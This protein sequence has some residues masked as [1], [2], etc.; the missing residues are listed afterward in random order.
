MEQESVIAYELFG[1]VSSTWRC[2]SSV[3]H[4]GEA[5]QREK[6]FLQLHNILVSVAT[7]YRLYTCKYEK[8]GVFSSTLAA[9]SSVLL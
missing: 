4:V 6:V 9:E 2:I 8:R 1:D 3:L 7:V 5:E